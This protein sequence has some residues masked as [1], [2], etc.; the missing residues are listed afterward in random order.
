MKIRAKNLMFT[1]MTTASFENLCSFLACWFGHGVN[2]SFGTPPHRPLFPT[3]E[4]AVA[5][6]NTPASGTSPIKLLK[7]RFRYV[8]S[9]IRTYLYVC[10]NK[11]YNSLVLEHV[12]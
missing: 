7:E 12:I 2:L 5:S 11:F 8:R 6:R 9:L 3:I 1:D 10:S 4:N